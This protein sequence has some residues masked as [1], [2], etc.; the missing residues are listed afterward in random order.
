M[1]DKAEGLR[2]EGQKA[3]MNAKHAYD[4]ALGKA[5][6][7]ELPEVER[8]AADPTLSRTLT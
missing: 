2:H 8:T 3:E 1:K 5:S 4:A 7:A 6:G